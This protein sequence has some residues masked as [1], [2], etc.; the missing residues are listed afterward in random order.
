MKVLVIVDMQY[1]FVDGALGTPEAQAIVPLMAETM[2]QLADENTLILFT[3]DT[4]TEDYM[5]TL[6][7]KNLP[8]PHCIKGT[9]GWTLIDELC[10]PYADL[11]GRQRSSKTIFTL[12]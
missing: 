6:E 8:I 10:I 2:T 9:H 5:N 4:H 11:F 12:L 3:K 1:D 7:G